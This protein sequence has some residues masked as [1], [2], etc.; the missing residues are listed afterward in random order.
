MRMWSNIAVGMQNGTATLE[1]S[2]EI[3]YKSKHTLTR[4]SSNHTPQYLPKGAENLVHSKTYTQV[5]VTALFII[6]KTWKQ[7]RCPLVGE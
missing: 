6:A 7:V 2:L 4:G 1:D 5:F 3:S